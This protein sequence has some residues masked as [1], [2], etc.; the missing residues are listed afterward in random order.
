MLTFL[1]T[2]LLIGVLWYCAETYVPLV[3]PARVIIRV[4][5]LVVVV[6]FVARFFG[7]L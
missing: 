3:P 7:V 6:L 1:L 2:L 5:F 4:V